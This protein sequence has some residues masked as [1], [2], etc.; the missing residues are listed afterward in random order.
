MSSCNNCGDFK[1]YD[2]CCDKKEPTILT[3]KVFDENDVPVLVTVNYEEEPFNG[4]VLTGGEFD[5]SVD[6]SL[7]LL[8][9]P[10]GTIFSL[11]LNLKTA[12]TTTATGIVINSTSL[13]GSIEK[14]NNIVIVGKNGS[15]S[16]LLV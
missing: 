9:V 14:E 7:N 3:K 10:T 8:N 4:L 1:I 12:E 13:T 2:D 11:V 16:R 5:T 15:A 6:P